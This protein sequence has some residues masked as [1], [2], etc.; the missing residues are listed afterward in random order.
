[1]Q[2]GQRVRIIPAPG[3]SWGRAEGIVTRI[4]L[5]DWEAPYE[6]RVRLKRRDGS[7]IDIPFKLNEVEIVEETP[8]PEWENALLTGNPLPGE[9]NDGPG[10]CNL[11]VVFNDGETAT[12]SI[13]VPAKGEAVVMRDGNVLAEDKNMRCYTFPNVRYWY[14]EA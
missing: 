4:P 9:D 11:T 12:V 8:I 1:M 5:E 3:H 6:V 7:E 13:L 14:T 2:V 10:E